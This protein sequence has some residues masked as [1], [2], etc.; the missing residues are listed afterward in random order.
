MATPKDESVVNEVLTLVKS[1]LPTIVP[2][3]I[4]NPQ[5]MNSVLFAS[6]FMP[7]LLV[8]LNRVLEYIRLKYKRDNFPVSVIVTNDT[9]LLV[10]NFDVSVGN[11]LGRIMNI[12]GIEIPEV[13]IVN[14]ANRSATEI[15][16]LDA[17]VTFT[18][19]KM[20]KLLSTCE[21]LI[22]SHSKLSGV[23]AK[24]EG[25]TVKIVVAVNDVTISGRN[26]EELIIF[27]EFLETLAM[28]TVIA[29]GL[30]QRYVTKKLPHGSH[31]DTQN[32]FKDNKMSLSDIM[33]SKNSRIKERIGVWKG[34]ADYYKKHN[35]TH[36]ISLLV[37]GPPGTGKTLLATAIANELGYSVCEMKI[38][39]GNT[40]I[41]KECSLTMKNTVYLFDEIDR[42][43]DSLTSVTVKNVNDKIESS[44]VVNVREKCVLQLMGIL[45]K[46]VPS[47][48]VILFTTNKD[49]S[50]FEPALIRSGRVDYIEELG[51][52]DTS[53]FE[54]L[55]KKFVGDDLDM[56][57]FV[58]PENKYS[59]SHLINT[60]LV[61]FRKDSKKIFELLK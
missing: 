24:L 31:M 36:K 45:D 18:P 26:R 51:M 54:N 49:P 56:H 15:V 8:I 10:G 42:M 9:S 34:E 11:Y 58:F 39:D 53:Q 37:Y 17:V 1:N 2:M 13:K 35:L 5:G 6:L 44:C 7:C 12:L 22:K 46:S 55:Y 23:L 28:A 41:F 25:V 38:G 19:E 40:E 43:L 48:C 52:A 20:A 61:P 30:N 47:G 33:L 21:T 3:M 32:Y 60:V 16:K 27:Y 29:K 57:D 50:Q 14:L 4:I 59:P